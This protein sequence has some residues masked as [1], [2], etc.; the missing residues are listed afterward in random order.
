MSFEFLDE[1]IQELIKEKGFLEPSVVQNLSIKPIIDGHDVLV[2]APTGLG[3]TE[4]V[5]LPLFHNI[6]REKHKP[7][8]ALYI[9]P[10]KSLN[11]DL[12]DRLYWWGDKLDI[13]IT[14]RHGDTTQSER[15]AQREAPSHIF[16]TTPETLQA[17]LPGKIMKE[18]LKNI[19]YVIIDEIHELVE[20]KRGVQLSVALERLR[21]IS[22][23]FQRIGLSAT[24]GS[25]G[26]VAQFLSPKA[27]IL[28]AQ[29]DK[30]YDIRVES[31][32]PTKKD[33]II[34]ED[35]YIGPE[36]AARLRRIY[37]LIKAHQC[38][39]EN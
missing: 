17:I 11:R 9:T 29:H 28:K 36:T 31:P 39:L 35:L 3:K 7:I 23:D 16:I 15:T 21:K 32:K 1:K 34:A 26:L 25:P 8:A 2:I 4:A 12:L 27:R 6:V 20:S 30:I 24:V 38:L 22:G 33:L 19:K 13:E 18:H 5:C 10:L 14:V 37:D